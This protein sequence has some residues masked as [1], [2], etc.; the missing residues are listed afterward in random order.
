MAQE[1][2]RE[3]PR[4]T[5]AV[6]SLEDHCQ[7]RVELHIEEQELALDFD[8]S[9]PRGARVAVDAVEAALHEHI[10]RALELRQQLR[11][12]GPDAS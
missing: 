7:R 1:V 2:T 9:A 11:Q 10:E 3:D 8:D 4:T 5:V 6:L 12:G